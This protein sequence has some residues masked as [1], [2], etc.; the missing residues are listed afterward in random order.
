VAA[1]VA[2]PALPATPTLLL[3]YFCFLNPPFRLCPFGA[4][5]AKL[6]ASFVCRIMQVQLYCR[7]ALRCLQSRGHGC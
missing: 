5:P 4:T 7:D 1:S 3:S 6:G 2:V